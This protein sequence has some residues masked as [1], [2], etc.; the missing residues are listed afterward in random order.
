MIN[1]L[2]VMI[3]ILHEQLLNALYLYWFHNDILAE[4]NS[5]ND[6]SNKP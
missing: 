6:H 4:N 2:Y 3:K 1:I 5:R